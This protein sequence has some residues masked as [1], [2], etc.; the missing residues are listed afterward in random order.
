[1]ANFA[2]VINLSFSLSEALLAILLI[3]AIVA[4]VFLIKVLMGLSKTMDVVQ[5]IASD[6]KESIDATIVKL[7]SIVGSADSLLVKADGLV[8]E[9]KPQIVDTLVEVKG[10]TKNANKLSTDAADTVEYVVSSAVDTMHSVNKGVS[11]ATDYV[12]II[13]S[14]L[15]AIKN[16]VK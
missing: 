10:I 15:E 5:K 9:L 2:T 16:F 4:L 8:D 11:S 3:V 14:I 1:M 12:D 7:P 6:N 13:K